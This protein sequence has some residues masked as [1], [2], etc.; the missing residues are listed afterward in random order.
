MWQFG[1]EPSFMQGYEDWTRARPPRR[2]S[3][4]PGSFVDA[5]LSAPLVYQPETPHESFGFFEPAQ[6]HLWPDASEW[7][8]Q[9]HLWPE[10][11]PELQAMQEAAMWQHWEHQQAKHQRIQDPAFFPSVAAAQDASEASVGQY[12]Q[13]AVWEI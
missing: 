7:Q 2:P 9:T 10:P 12:P 1:M 4:P 8:H 3:P 6:A 11:G 5:T 13:Q